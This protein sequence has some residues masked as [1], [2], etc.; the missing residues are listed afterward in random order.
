[1]NIARIY[2]KYREELIDKFIKRYGKDYTPPNNMLL[3]RFGKI[4]HPDTPY[5]IWCNF[6][7]KYGTRR[8]Y[9]TL[10]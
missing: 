10:D 2:L 6:R 8:S 9:T 3:S 5:K 1:M 7:D 4:M